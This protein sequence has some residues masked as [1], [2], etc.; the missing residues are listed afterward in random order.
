M[1]ASPSPLKF[2]MPGWF[3]VVMGLTGLA[4]AWHRAVPAM[5]EMA[6]GISLVISL[7][8]AIVFLALAIASIARARRFPEAFRE[9][10]AHPVRHPF[11]AAIPISLILLATASVALAGASAWAR[12]AWWVGALA[13]LAVTAWVVAK[14]WRGNQPGGIVWPALTPALVIPV[15]G[16]VLVPLA[17]IPL[18]HEDWS[19]AQFAVGL[20]FWPIVHALIAVRLATQGSWPERLQPAVFIFVAP[21]SVV[22]LAFAQFG[23]HPMLAWGAWGLALFSLLTALTQLRRIL[24][25]PFAIPHWAMSFPLAAFS[26]LTLRLGPAGSAIAGAGILALA[27][28]SL[29]I[30]ALAFATVKGLRD[31][32]LLAPEPVAAIQPAAAAQ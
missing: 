10:F 28:T 18:G 30:L 27:A 1:P 23:A 15:V 31:G 16:N 24:A 22:G 14:W 21:P 13:Q 17:G 32:T 6:G 29:V 4:L 26:A 20:F 5:G 25:L 2:L 9:D 11:V 3:A 12:A 8:A 19:A 7:A